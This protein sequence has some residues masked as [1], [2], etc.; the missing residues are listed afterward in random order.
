LTRTRN[1]S[2]SRQW[3]V[4]DDLTWEHLVDQIEVVIAKRDWLV[5]R[6]VSCRWSPRAVA[7]AATPAARSIACSGVMA[8]PISWASSIHSVYLS[9]ATDI[10]PLER[11]TR[12]FTL[13]A[14]FHAERAVNGCLLGCPFGN[15][16]LEMT[17]QD[18]VIRDAIW[19]VFGRLWSYFEHALEDA[20][21]RDQIG[22][23][24]ARATARRLF[25]YLHGVCLMSKVD[26]DPRVFLEMAP[27][28]I[29][30]IR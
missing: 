28:A 20:R 22:E 16:A 11:F 10:P 4:T 24:D 2:I 15:L 12:F 17:T 6:Y 9:G 29:R 3:F 26:N 25:T 14:A 1:A 21:A 27:G 19:D 30:L 13:A 7:S 23:I 5:Q 18:I 8:I